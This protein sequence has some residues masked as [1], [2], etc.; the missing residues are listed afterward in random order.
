M[1]NKWAG[2]LFLCIVQRLLQLLCIFKEK[3]HF[4][5]KIKKKTNHGGHKFKEG[6][7]GIFKVEM[8]EL[9]YH[10]IKIF[11]NTKQFMY[12]SSLIFTQYCYYRKTDFT[13]VGLA[14]KMREN[15]IP[16]VC[17]LSL[18]Q[19]PLKKSVKRLKKFYILFPFN[20][21]PLWTEGVER[22][23]KTKR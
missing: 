17:L 18:Y 22:S 1:I 12:I 2:S 10:H 19:I 20:E 14:K 8:E 11:H 3:I 15:G 5:Y 4:H 9:P 23:I 13:Y 21:R 6:D 16:S 7:T